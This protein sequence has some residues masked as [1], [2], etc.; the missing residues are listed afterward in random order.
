[1]IKSFVYLSLAALIFSSCQS[2]RSTGSSSA[3]QVE[4]EPTVEE[5]T[6]AP[7]KAQNSSAELNRT[8]QMSEGIFS[9]AEFNPYDLKGEKIHHNF[10]PIYFAFNSA[11]VEHEHRGLLGK[12]ARY[13]A[14]NPSFH[15]VVNGHCDERG[16][17]E[18]NRNL[19]ER[20]AMAIR[21]VIL[22]FHNIS[23]R[24][25][26]IGYGEEALATTGQSPSDHA[27][28]RRG[29]FDIIAVAQ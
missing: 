28:N 7:I 24:V 13:I 25:H 14:Q 21:D 17:N 10:P 18:Y 9:Q 15:L 27:V 3:M 22:S 4:A 16:D 19:S 2:P 11:S 8:Q 29:E 5:I 12:I 6:S 20:R 1:M 26:T 23:A